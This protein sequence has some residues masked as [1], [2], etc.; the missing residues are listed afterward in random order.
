MTVADGE[1][2]MLDLINYGRQNTGLGSVAFGHNTAAQARASSMLE[3]CFLSHR[4]PDGL[5]PYMHCSLAGR[6]QANAEN[7]HGVIF[8][9]GRYPVVELTDAIRMLWMV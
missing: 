6:Y 7:L 2:F 8:C 5:K 9:S 3:N 1:Q 4:G